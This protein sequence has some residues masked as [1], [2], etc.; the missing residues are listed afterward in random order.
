MEVT[1]HLLEKVV[2]YDN[3]R[4]AEIVPTQE[5]EPRPFPHMLLESLLDG[6]NFRLTVAF[7]G[8]GLRSNT[9]KSN[10]GFAL[11]IFGKEPARR[12]RDEKREE[13]ND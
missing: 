8:I 6:L 13:D 2:N 7:N 12:A 3:C 5:I 11:T 10:D 9:V 4:S 1:V